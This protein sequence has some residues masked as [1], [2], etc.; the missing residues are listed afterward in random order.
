MRSLLN[1]PIVILILGL[2]LGGALVGSYFILRPQSK[3]AVQTPGS[4]KFYD[5]FFNDDFFG[6]SKDPFAEMQRMQK[7]MLSQFGD[8]NLEG[9]FNNWY[10]KRFGGG[11]VG[12]FSQREDDDFIYYDI[13]TDKKKPEELKVDVK[14]GQVTVSGKFEEKSDSANSNSFYSSSFTRSF[15]APQNTDAEK[16]KIEQ[17]DGK[18][19]I[20]FPKKKNRAD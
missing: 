11:H 9:P 7:Q 20:K 6:R 13:D 8:Q 1:K 16:F 10:Q 17:A 15:P 4:E 14:N 2:V 18:V 3:V 19:I 12:D 5:Q